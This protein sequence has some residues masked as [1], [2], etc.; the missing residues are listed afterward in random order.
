M[1]EGDILAI[2]GIMEERGG[3][4][5]LTFGWVP[6][7]G[8]DITFIPG[9]NFIH[10]HV[11]TAPAKP[12]GPTPANGAT[13]VIDVVASWNPPKGVEGS[14]YNVYAGTDP[15]ALELLAE[16]LTEPTLSVGS[17]GVD[18]DVA[19]TYYWRVDADGVEGF[20]WSFTTED[21]AFL[22]EDV[23]A[24]SASLTISGGSGITCP[25]RVQRIAVSIRRPG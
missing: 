3:G 19:T 15:A 14:T 9:E 23:V 22:V 4:D 17:A 24:S 18:L 5:S 11:V 1:T 10:E 7:E 6:P 25:V 13:D 8:G 16:G 2:Y 21:L 12:T 20:V